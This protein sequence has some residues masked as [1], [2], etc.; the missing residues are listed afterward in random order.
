MLGKR[1]WEAERSNDDPAVFGGDNGCFGAV[2]VVFLLLALAHAVDI[3]FMET[4]H[5]AFAC[6]G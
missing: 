6:L 4:E 2:L 5:L 3:G 1:G